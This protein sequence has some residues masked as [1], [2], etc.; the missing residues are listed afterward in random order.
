MAIGNLIG[1]SVYNICA[2]LGVTCLVVG[3]GIPVPQELTSMDIPFMVTVALLCVPVFF[4]GRAVSRVEGGLFVI[5]YAAYLGGS[6]LD[7]HM[8]G[9]SG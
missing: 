8:S 4:S 3:E 1:S 5:V 2:I 7:P 9:L 6:A